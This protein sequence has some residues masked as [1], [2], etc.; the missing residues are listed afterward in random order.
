MRVNNV[1]NV[2]RKNSNMKISGLEMRATIF[3]TLC[4]AGPL[5]CKT[6]ILPPFNMP[7]NFLET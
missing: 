7:Q 1:F 3:D 6:P 5:F 2:P 4:R